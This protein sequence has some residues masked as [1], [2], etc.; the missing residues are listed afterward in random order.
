MPEEREIRPRQMKIFV[1]DLERFGHTPGCSQC[2]HVLKY[3][4]NRPGLSHTPQCR[5]RVMKAMAETDDMRY[6][7]EG[8]EERLTRYLSERVEASDVRESNGR[9]GSSD[10][11][12][13]G[14]LPQDISGLPPREHQTHP[15]SVRGVIGIPADEELSETQRGPQHHDDEVPTNNQDADMGEYMDADEPMDADIFDDEPMEIHLLE[16]T[17]SEIMISQMGGNARNY[18]RERKAAWHRMVSEVYSP[19]RVTALAKAMPS[20]GIIPGMAMDLTVA[21]RD[22]VCW[23]FD[24]PEIREK[25]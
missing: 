9:P 20:F 24:R 13:A 15:G 19:P 12:S 10:D 8:Q 18:I 17:M 25:A 4:Q 11:P 1:K 21:G 3:R 16:D 5:E 22:G 7:V 2:E 14:G 23:D 6:R